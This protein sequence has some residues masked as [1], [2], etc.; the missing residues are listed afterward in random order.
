[1]LYRIVWKVERPNPLRMSGPKAPIP[2][3]TREMQKTRE[4]HGIEI[5]A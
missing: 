2:P 3:D 5:S 4:K 1:M